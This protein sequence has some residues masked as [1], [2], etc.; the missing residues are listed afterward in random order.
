MN[1]TISEP[2]QPDSKLEQMVEAIV[3]ETRNKQ[4]RDLGY[5]PETILTEMENGTRTDPLVGNC[6]ENANR[7]ASELKAV[8]F[9]PDVVHGAIKPRKGAQSI[10]TTTEAKK[11]GCVHYWVEVPQPRKTDAPLIAEMAAEP[12]GGVRVTESLPE[13]YIHERAIKS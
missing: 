3:I 5:D 13:S 9:D 1:E 7:L 12:D 11:L 8:G 10:S 2:K 6:V 4:L